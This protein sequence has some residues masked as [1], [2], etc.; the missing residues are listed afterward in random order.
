MIKHRHNMDYEFEEGRFVRG[1]GSSWRGDSYCK[2]KGCNY[3]VFSREA[4][5]MQMFGLGRVRTQVMPNKDEI[6]IVD[7][8]KI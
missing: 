6:Y 1:D 2:I 4:M 7:N 3:A 8:M 5:R